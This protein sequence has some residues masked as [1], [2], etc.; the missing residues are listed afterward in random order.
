MLIGPKNWHIAVSTL[1]D[2]LFDLKESRHLVVCGGTA[3][4]ILDI[5]QRETRDIDIIVPEVD[6]ILRN[7]ANAVAK[8]LSLPQDWIND[9]PK[10]LADE[11]TTGWR[12]RVQRLYQGKALTI[13]ALG[14]IDLLAT[15]MYAFC[16]RED[17]FQDVINLRPTQ[18]ELKQ[19]YPWVMDRDASD[20]WPNRVAS[21]F[22]RVEKVL[23]EK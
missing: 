18:S 9:G 5:I 3:L 15:K 21:C 1:D 19:I 22:K 11:L 4:L 16:D 13:D 20:L 7:V 8:K 14:R 6:P 17:D 2:I 10:T 23:Y 12:E